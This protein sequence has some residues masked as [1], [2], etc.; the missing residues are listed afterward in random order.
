M[1]SGTLFGQT[2]QLKLERTL[3]G[4]T[5][6]VHAAPISRDGRVLASASSDQTVKL[7]DIET[8]REVAVGL[9]D[10]ARRAYA[11]AARERRAALTR[12]FYHVPMDHVFVPT[13]QSPVEPVLSLFA[14]RMKA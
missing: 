5:K 13:D 4:H 12:A 2:P 11:E 3:T 10:R 14:K 6:N 8:G 9:S 1:V 7:W